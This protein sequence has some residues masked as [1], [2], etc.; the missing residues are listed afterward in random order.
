MIPLRVFISSVQKEFAVE[1]RALRD[2]LHADPLLSQFF[3]PVLFEDLPAVDKRADEVYLHEVD[4]C[5]FYLGLFG[6]AYGFLD[7]NGVSPT[8]HEYNRAASL[9]RPR[10]IFVGDPKDGMMRDA[11][12]QALVDRASDTVIR[13]RFGSES[14]L[15][16]QVYAALVNVLKDRKLLRFGPFD[17]EPCTDARLVDIDDDAVARFVQIARRSRG[18]SLSEGIPTADALVHLNLLRDEQPVN[19]AMLLFARQPQRFL[20]ASEVKCAHYHGTQV[21]KPIP[22]HQV[23]RGTVFSMIDE[24]VNFVMSKIDLRVGTRAQGPQAPVEYEIPREVVSEAIVNAVAHRDYTSAGGV[25]VMLFADR[26]EVW[27]PGEL[28]ATLTLANLRTAHGSVPRNPLLAEP[29]YLARYIERMGTGTQDMIRRCREAGL[30]E[31]EFAVRDGFVATIFRPQSRPESRPE[32]KPELK[33]ESRPESHPQSRPQSR[34]HSQPQ[35]QPQSLEA[36]VLSLLEAGPIARSGIVSK[37]GHKAL[38]GQ[39]KIVLRLLL[40]EENAEWTIPQTPKSRLQRYRIT[41]KGS[42]RLAALRTERASP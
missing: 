35:S 23:Y 14:E 22:S 18:V 2:Y 29:L 3:T 38:S 5:D 25:Q 6:T 26:L 20:S 24:A 19:A 1:R 39:L 17:A 12:M 40:D 34:P 7:A 8:E 31:P 21:A 10:L 36:R 9:H 32:L 33:P 27:N 13:R 28:P 15:K 37:L 11:R 16:V 30:R 41:A 42:E 4:R